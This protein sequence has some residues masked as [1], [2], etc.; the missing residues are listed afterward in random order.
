MN[1]QKMYKSTYSKLFLRSSDKFSIAKNG[2]DFLLLSFIEIV[3]FTI[4]LVDRRFV[5]GSIGN[6]FSSTTTD[7]EGN[8]ILVLIAGA[9]SAGAASNHAN[10]VELNVRKSTIVSET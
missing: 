4:V 2:L 1:F 6:S 9:L 3:L 8:L 5:H 10:Q 7:V